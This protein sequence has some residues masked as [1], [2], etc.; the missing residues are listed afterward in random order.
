M[1]V[2][3]MLSAIIFVGSGFFL[4]T[5]HIKNNLLTF[6]SFFVCYKRRDRS[7]Q[8]SNFLNPEAPLAEQLRQ[9]NREEKGEGRKAHSFVDCIS[10][11][12]VDHTSQECL[13]RLARNVF[14]RIVFSVYFIS[15]ALPFFQS[16]PFK[17]LPVRGTS[18]SF[19]R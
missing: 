12:A 14:S 16:S 13:P 19:K 3:V 6:L 5:R 2:R 11:L 8:I 17:P 9:P 1:G 4:C 15:K 7:A 18:T 10:H